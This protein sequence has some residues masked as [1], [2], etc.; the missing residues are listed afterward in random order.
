MLATLWCRLR[1][2]RS[3][4]VRFFFLFAPRP[5]SS[6]SAWPH[7]AT[8]SPPFDLPAGAASIGLGALAIL[9]LLCAAVGSFASARAR[10]KAAK[11]SGPVQAATLLASSVALILVCTSAGLCG[12]AAFSVAQQM[13]AVLTE[14]NIGSPPSPPVPAAGIGLA[15]AAAL[16]AAGA[17]AL[18]F[19]VFC[20]VRPEV[21]RV[22]TRAQ[23]DDIVVNPVPVR[24]AGRAAQSDAA[25]PPRRSSSRGSMR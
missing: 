4:L 21:R 8:R 20:L 2:R 19:G 18:D 9:A 25:P 3:K 16:L 12:A 13:N 7:A 1:M 23:G 10:A 17:L 22:G 14:A 15:V 6:L 11:P 24:K 5:R